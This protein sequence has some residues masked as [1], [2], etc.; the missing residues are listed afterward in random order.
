MELYAREL[1]IDVE[2]D[3][4][5]DT[6]LV[7]GSGT[8]ADGGTYVSDEE[9]AR[10]AQWTVV[11]RFRSDAGSETLCGVVSSVPDVVADVLLRG[12]GGIGRGGGTAS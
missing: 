2:S 1:Q 3:G 7:S 6:D 10:E 4:V 9:T 5:N 8:G 12:G 11:G